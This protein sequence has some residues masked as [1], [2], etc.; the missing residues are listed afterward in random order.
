MK[1]IVTALVLLSLSSVAQAN[2]VREGE[3]V[4]GQPCGEGVSEN[5]RRYVN[6]GEDQDVFYCQNGKW[7]HLMRLTPEDRGQD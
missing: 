1:L 2:T 3:I 5:E 4:E 7:K 6:L